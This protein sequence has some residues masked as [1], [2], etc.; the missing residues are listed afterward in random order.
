[1]R[2]ARPCRALASA[3]LALAIGSCGGTP[4]ST[5]PDGAALP[6][7]VPVPTMAATTFCQIFIPSCGT[8]LAGYTSMSACVASYEALTTTKPMRQACQSRHL[9]QATGYPT[10]ED[11][12]RHCLHAT[13]A[14][15]NME[16][17]DPN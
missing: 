4:G 12:D 8:A 10:G 15:G 11:R 7:C 17:E 1:M 13:G 5:P 6:A 3:A 2:L 14:P 16:C 9:C